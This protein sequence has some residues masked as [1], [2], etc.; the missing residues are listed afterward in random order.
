MINSPYSIGVI[1][2]G[3]LGGALVHGFS[4]HANIKIYDKFKAGFDTLEDTVKTSEYLF[5][6][7]PTP[8]FDDNGEQDLGI[9]DG[10]V[11]VVHDEVLKLR[12]AGDHARKIAVIK[13][14]VLPGA[15]RA[16]QSKY[17]ELT[18]VSGPE[19]L[20][21]RSNKLDFIC[22]SRHIFG[23]QDQEALRAMDSLFRFR[24]G[25]SVP[26]YLTDWESAEM[27]KYASNCFFA[28]KVN[29]F[30]Y[31]YKLCD[32]LDIEYNDVKDMVL[33]DGR[34]G[35]SHCDVPGHD[36]G[37][38]ISGTCFPKDLNALI[39]F[40]NNIGIDPQILEATWKQN[41]ELRPSKDWEQLSGV[42]SKRKT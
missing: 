33:A 25:N 38:G 18:F 21:A 23:G 26:I 17:P 10:A 34:I 39:N 3:F 36:G 29:Y 20:T 31:I 27:V 4:L 7:L 16:F 11:Q 40:S 42:V 30:N 5:F 8:M 35:R 13:S 41:I 37:F 19:F 15:N 32:K 1:G 2:Y 22:A 12:A 28:V 9:L 6:C 14:T 24:F